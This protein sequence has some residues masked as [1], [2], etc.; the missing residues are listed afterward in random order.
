M[1][2]FRTRL[3]SEPAIKHPVSQEPCTKLASDLLRLYGHYFILIADYNSKF[4]AVENLKIPNPLPL[5]TSVRKCI[6]SMVFLRN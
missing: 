6:R 3:P 1:F 5:L 2:D 4:V